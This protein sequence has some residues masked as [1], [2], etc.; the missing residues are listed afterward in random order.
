MVLA[1][2][3]YAFKT[4]RQRGNK[5]ERRKRNREKIQKNM[6]LENWMKAPP[7]TASPSYGL[8]ERSAKQ[9]SSGGA[10]EALQRRFYLEWA[11]VQGRC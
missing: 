11:S 1:S 9:D 10:S 7:E 5:G 3:N 6:E 2:H 4:G 8:R